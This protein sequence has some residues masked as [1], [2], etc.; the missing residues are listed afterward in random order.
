[1]LIL[2]GTLLQAVLIVAMRKYN[3]SFVWLIPAVVAIQWMFLAAY[4]SKSMDF[5]VAWFIATGC[6]GLAA[7]AC[8]FL[9]FGERLAWQQIAG[10]V[11]VV[12]GVL[13]LR[14]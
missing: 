11:L 3:I 14:A 12:S 7:V 13:V 4:A 2:G 5:T 10:I 9:F 6:T 1:L 8:G